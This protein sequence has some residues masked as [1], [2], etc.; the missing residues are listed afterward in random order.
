MKSPQNRSS[1]SVAGHMGAAEVLAEV[2]RRRDGAV[3]APGRL[4]C[5]HMD[6][7]RELLDGQKGYY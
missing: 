5:G 3:G 7:I 6:A 1:G 4:L 2:E